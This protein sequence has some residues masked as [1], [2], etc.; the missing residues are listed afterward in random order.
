MKIEK[1]DY[2]KLRELYKEAQNMP[3][4]VSTDTKELFMKGTWADQAWDAVRQC[5]DE[6]GR[7]YDYDPKKYGIGKE[8]ELIKL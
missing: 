8:G 3:A 2:D 6:L 1:E 5:M 7:K 4:I